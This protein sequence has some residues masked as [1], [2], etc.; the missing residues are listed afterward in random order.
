MFV[1]LEYGDCLLV[2]LL[3]M[4]DTEARGQGLTCARQTSTTKPYVYPATELLRFIFT[5]AFYFLRQ[6]LTKSPVW[7]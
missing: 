2:C 7:P 1:G 5:L 4:C 6:G 3:S